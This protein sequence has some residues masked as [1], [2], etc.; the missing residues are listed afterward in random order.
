M[1]YVYTY[2]DP[3]PTKNSQVVYVGKGMGRRAWQ[4][5]EKQVKGNK[6][7]GNL[8]ALLRNEGRAPVI[9]IV[10]RHDSEL[11]AFA[12]EIRLIALYG[13]RDLKTGPLFN[14]T[15]GGEGLWGALR[16]PEWLERMHDAAST[17]AQKQR[18]S[19]ASLAKWADPLWR[20]KTTELIRAAL[21]DP[22]VIRRREE[23]KA[24]FTGTPA[25]KET[26]RQATLRM[27]EDPEY[28]E[29]VKAA[30]KAAQSTPESRSKKAVNSRKMWE[31]QGDS[32]KQKITEARNTPESKALSGRKAKD[33]WADPEY[34]ARQ[35]ANNQEISRRPEV[36]A[37]RAA[38]TKAMWVDPERRAKMLAARAAGRAGVAAGS[39]S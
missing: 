36:L 21:K 8:L 32:L 23:G 2:R 39:V 31:Q 18:M 35:T 7:F 22:D 10:S 1:F 12:E 33:M 19:A 25:F 29:R 17:P 13:R 28:A 14:L 6:G 5:W 37:A 34:A 4:H 9:E 24:L 15:D 3:R 11:D 16:T 38:A 26:M 30:Q 27:W 20:A